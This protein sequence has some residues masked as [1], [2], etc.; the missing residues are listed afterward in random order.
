[1]QIDEA[2]RVVEGVMAEARR[3]AVELSVAVADESGHLVA[4]GRMDG[5]PFGTMDVALD[6]AHSAAAFAAPTSRW[7]ASSAPG[8][9]NWGF[10]AALGGRMTVYGGGLPIMR[11]GRL[12]GAV[13]VSGAAADVDESC[14]AAGIEAAGLDTA[15]D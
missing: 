2:G 8:G 5:A 10:H 14:A 12:I 15:R 4:A 1:M 6:K 7:A 3:R 11:D 13:G 9:S